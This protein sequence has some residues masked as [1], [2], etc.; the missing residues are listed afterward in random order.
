VRRGIPG[1]V[2]PP[3][4]PI[5]PMRPSLTPLIFLAVP[6][7][8]QAS[9]E[10]LA[11]YARGVFAEL[12]GD[13]GGARTHYEAVLAADPASFTAARKASAIQLADDDLPAAAKTLRGFAVGHPDR[14]APQLCYADFLEQH[15]P[16]DADA[17]RAAEAVLTAANERF[18]HHPEVFTRLVN[19]HENRARRER[20]LAVFNAQF[21]VAEAGPEH[22][23]ALAPIARTL[24]PAGSAELRERLDL[25]AANLVRTGI[26][27]PDM[28]RFASDHYR[29]TGRLDQAIAVL[30]KHAAAAPDSLALR[31]RLGLLL[32]SAQRDPEAL[33]VLHKVL[34]IDPEKVIAH[35]SLA[36]YYE[37]HQ[38]PGKALF[39]HAE[40]LRLAGG[41]VAQF[42][43]VASR[44]LELDRPHEARLLLEKARF[45]HPDDPVIAARFAVATLRDG[46]PAAA[47]RLF[48]RAEALAE[49]SGDSA[50]LDALG[51]GFQ[52]EFAFS[53]RDAG[54]LP[55]A[56]DR[57]R[58]AIRDI[59]PDQSAEL[60]RALRALAALW[61]DQH[62]NRGPAASLLKRAD[63]LEPN[64]PETQALLERTN[65]SESHPK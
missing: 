46:D 28:A 38:A 9:E 40:V 18:P 1:G 37:R 31:T 36:R 64:H 16:H 10:T 17:Q 23:R 61:L 11:R 57:L 43:A 49:A 63:A 25:V 15:A 29:N 50:A 48:R 12:E 8:G 60:A 53:L 22:W 21:E 34:E 47:A 32:L 7:L 59:P 58:A 55:E 52:I 65:K 45:D 33:E 14:L 56:E 24:L 44:Y 2:G 26:E 5:P 4:G 54:D 13:L 41:D 27:R 42:T 62:K 19:V 20:S 35:R 6:A 30:E 39:H 51:P 3:S